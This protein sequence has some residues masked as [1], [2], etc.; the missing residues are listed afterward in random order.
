MLTSS[1]QMRIM[2]DVNQTWAKWYH[3]LALVLA[4]LEHQMGWVHC[5][6]RQ[7]ISQRGKSQLNRLQNTFLVLSELSGIRCIFQYV[8]THVVL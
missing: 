1:L 5:I 4:R 7:F 3:Y 8:P 2:A 6:R